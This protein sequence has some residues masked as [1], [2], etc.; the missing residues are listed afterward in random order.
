MTEI[1][2]IKNKS[3]GII[4]SAL[5]FFLLMLCAI[6]LSGSIAE[7]TLN[8]MRFSVEVILPSVFPF[9]VFSDF[10]SN[11]YCFE[12]TKPYRPALSGFSE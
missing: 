1:S 2:Y 12:T 3:F 10:A 4:K 9:M 5:A 11:L 8:G 7:E 6:F